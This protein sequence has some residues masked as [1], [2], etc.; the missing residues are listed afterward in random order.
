V[1]TLPLLE[2]LDG[3]EKMS[4]SLGNTVGITDAPEEMF[5]KLMSISDDLMWRYYELLSSVETADLERLR[6]AVSEGRAHP[7]RAKEDLAREMVTR[8]H[9][10]GKAAEA[11]A[12]FMK[13][14]RNR[15][16]P[17]RIETTRIEGPLPL[18]KLLANAGLAKSSSEARRLVAQGAVKLD[19]AVQTDP[20]AMV[21]V[22]GREG[23]LV[24][25]G[26]RRFRR[27]V[28]P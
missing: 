21:E 9:D 6:L 12:Q 11:E 28:A 22:G 24:Q 15:E 17:E 8:F 5:G 25:V 23:V 16:A 19:G 1:L 26:K 7:M 4:K 10:A 20:E 14:H 27:V 18:F 2:G 13:V 3:K